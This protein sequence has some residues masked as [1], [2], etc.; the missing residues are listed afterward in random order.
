MRR[1]LLFAVAFGASLAITGAATVLGHSGEGEASIQDE[2]GSVTA[3]GTVVLAGTG[4]EP[5][6]DRVLTLVGPSLI[7]EFGTVRTDAEG[8][9]STELTVPSHLPS[10]QY[11]FQAIGDETLTV[12]LAVTA[13][14]GAATESSGAGGPDQTVVVR[15]RSPLE[16]G[17]LLAFV[18]LAAIAGALLAWRAE[19]FRGAATG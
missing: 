17:F 5:D 16:L 3:G 10:G 12:P 2:P 4:L 14:A 6:T 8:M 15:Q 19:R 1:S 7:I 18:A 11:A 9:F 13:A